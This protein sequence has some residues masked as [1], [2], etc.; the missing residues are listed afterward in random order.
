MDCGLILTSS[1]FAHA[2]S[3]ALCAAI[4]VAVVLNCCAHAFRS[5][6]DHDATSRRGEGPAILEDTPRANPRKSGVRGVC[7]P[8]SLPGSK[9]AALT[10]PTPP[11]G[12]RVFNIVA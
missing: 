5:F 9:T 3:F 2:L 4:V 1:T 6:P 10:S 11:A 7:G 8:S 12:R